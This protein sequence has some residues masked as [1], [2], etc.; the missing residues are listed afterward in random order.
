MET[1]TD[2]HGATWSSND[3][4]SVFNSKYE[5]YVGKGKLDQN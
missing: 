1:T 5:R 4:A 2:E 3:W